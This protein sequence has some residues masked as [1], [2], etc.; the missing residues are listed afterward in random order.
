[1]GNTIALVDPVRGVELRD[2]DD[3]AV[4]RSL[5]LQDAPHARF[6]GLHKGPGD[7]LLA[8]HVDGHVDVWDLESGALLDQVKLHGAPSQILVEGTAVVATT[9]VGDRAV[10]DLGNQERAYCE[11]LHEVWSDVPV[12]W[13]DGCP[14]AQEPPADHRC[15][16]PTEGPTGD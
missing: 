15:A 12:S 16:E 1:M 2:P 11:L 5:R 3:G 7:T 13:T 8:T 4:Q 6:I 9:D 10:M 14:L